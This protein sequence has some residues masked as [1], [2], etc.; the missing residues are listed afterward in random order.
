MRNWELRC[1]ATRTILN[2]APR[3]VERALAAGRNIG[4]LF[5]SI[6]QFLTQIGRGMEKRTAKAVRLGSSAG[7][8]RQAKARQPSS[9]CRSRIVRPA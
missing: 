3:V 7:D 6:L 4:G 2:R 1:P 9:A 5:E 8:H